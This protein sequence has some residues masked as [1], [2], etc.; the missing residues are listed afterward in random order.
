MLY[1]FAIR[2]V[3][4]SL[5]SGGEL[6]P[7]IA[8]VMNNIYPVWHIWLEV[9]EF[10]F[11][12][13]FF[14]NGFGS[15]SVINNYYLNELAVINPNSSLIRMIYENG[16]IGIILFVFVFLKPLKIL[17]VDKKL[18]NKLVFLMLMM[19]GMYFAH[20][21]ASLYIFLG[22]AITVYKRKSIATFSSS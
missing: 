14:G 6:S 9:K 18:L 7:V 10:N 5:D 16:I 12:H 1:V 20:R 22:I 11:F 2:D 17:C 8:N 19:L 3:Y 13:L 4:Q 15:A 21:S